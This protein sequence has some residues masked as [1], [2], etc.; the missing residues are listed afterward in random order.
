MYSTKKTRLST[1]TFII[2]FCKPAFI[3]KS[4]LEIK[5]QQERN[6]K[7]TLEEQLIDFSFTENKMSEVD[8]I[9]VSTE[10]Y[11]PDMDADGDGQVSKNEIL[12]FFKSLFNKKEDKDL[13]GEIDANGDGKITQEE[14]DKYN[15]RTQ[16][17][18]DQIDEN[19]DGIITQDE[20]DNYNKGNER[21]EENISTQ[22]E[23]N[24]SNPF[25]PSFKWEGDGTITI[26]PLDLELQNE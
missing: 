26:K 21:E 16:D 24:I 9:L 22:P 23:L 6:V 13:T 19:G 4:I 1:T 5:K 7:N 12:E 20:V 14:L 2:N 25:G 11:L 15:Y 17:I 8:D 3:N 10:D 18:K